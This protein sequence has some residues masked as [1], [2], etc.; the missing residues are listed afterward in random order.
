[1]RLLYTRRA[2]T[3]L[4]EISDFYARENPAIG[5]ALFATIALLMDHLLIMPRLGRETDVENVRVLVVP[6]Y[7]YRIFYHLGS[8]TISVLSIFHTGRDP[9]DAP[10]T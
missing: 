3:E 8:D 7:P 10:A 5:R 4:S 2:F 9:A 1:M 6:R